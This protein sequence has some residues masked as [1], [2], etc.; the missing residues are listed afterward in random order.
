MNR[1]HLIEFHEQP[2]VPAILR[3]GVTDYLRTA[4]EVAGHYKAVVPMV[5]EMLADQ[6]D[7]QI[8]D[9]GAGAGGGWAQMLPQLEEEMG[10]SVKL[11]LTDLNPNT[12]ALEALKADSQG[13]IDYVPTAVDARSVPKDVK[14]LR[15][16]L[17]IFHH[18]RPDDAKAVVKDADEKQQ[19]LLVIEIL[20][21]S[22]IQAIMILILAPILTLILTPRIRP[23][24]FWRIIF[25]YLIPILPLMIAWDGFVSVLRLYG[26]KSMQKLTEGLNGLDWES[27][28]LKKGSLTILYMKGKKRG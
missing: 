7:N 14:G 13:K 5:K 1:L 22:I 20:D 11:L 6:A 3:Q 15:T 24:R 27:G 19:P 17:N 8:V 18:L 21:N 9:L 16:M 23:F 28:K 12:P 26:P 2:W 25:T 10:E 4:T